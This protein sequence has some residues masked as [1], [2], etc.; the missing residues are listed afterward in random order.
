MYEVGQKLFVSVRYREAL[1]MTVTKVGR[2]WLELEGGVW[3]ADRETLEIDGKGYTSPGRA[4]AS[5]EE[6]EAYQAAQKRR[7]EDPVRKPAAS[8][9]PG[10]NGQRNHPSRRNHYSPSPLRA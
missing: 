3:R 8:E 5:R 7:K 4:Y 6:F 2:K 1:Y 9:R 10:Y